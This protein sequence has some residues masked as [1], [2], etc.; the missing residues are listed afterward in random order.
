M[1]PLDPEQGLAQL[2]EAE[3]RRA[4]EWETMLL[5]GEAETI[6]AAR[7]WHESVWNVELY[8]RGLKDDPAGWETAVGQMSRARDGFY[9]LAR[10]DLGIIGP[11]PPSGNWPRAWQRQDETN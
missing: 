2:A 7:R 11:P 4:T 9:A 3:A 5:V 8:A 6:A 1:D 10:R